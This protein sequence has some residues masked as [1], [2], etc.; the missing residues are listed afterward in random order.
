MKV[1]QGN[2]HYSGLE[3]RMKVKLREI[4]FASPTSSNSRFVLLSSLRSKEEPF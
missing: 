3:C 2:P 1:K 4:L